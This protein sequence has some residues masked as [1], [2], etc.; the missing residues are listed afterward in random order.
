MIDYL[1]GDIDGV[2][3]DTTYIYKL[4]IA[5]KRYEEAANTALLIANNEQEL[6]NYSLA[7]TTIFEAMRYLEDSHVKIPSAMRQKFILLHSYL[8]VKTLARQNNHT[9][10]ARLLLRVTQHISKF[11]Q[12]TVPILTS[13]VI[14][15]QRAGLKASCYEFASTL[16][17]PEYRSLM[18]P[19]LKRKVE[20][21]VRRKSTQNDDVVE[22]T[23]PCPLTGSL[24]PNYQLECPTTRDALPMCVV[25]GRHM[26]LDD[27]CFCP[28]SGAP[29][30]YSE[31]VRYINFQ[32]TPQSVAEDDMSNDNNPTHSHSKVQIIQAIDPVLGKPVSIENLRKSSHEE[33]IKYIRWFNNLVDEVEKDS[34][35]ATVSDDHSDNNSQIVRKESLQSDDSD[36][37]GDSGGTDDVSGD[38]LQL[39]Q[40]SKTGPRRRRHSRHKRQANKNS[41]RF[42]AA[43]A[44]RASKAYNK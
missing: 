20:A 8:L 23:S 6:G 44:R 13:A 15:C 21:I 30:L 4:Y 2:P 31:Y 9:G 37:D 39:M 40:S 38:E 14:E 25:T 5:L 22:G 27:W 17:R 11:P 41:T 35:D 3:K 34:T 1:T 36:C 28:V 7:H 19:D 43:K 32:L 24:I 16:M 26:V 42:R 12:H 29:A 18:N 10:A 33:A